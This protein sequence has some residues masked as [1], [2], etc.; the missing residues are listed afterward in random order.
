MY[1]K[2]MDIKQGKRKW[3]AVSARASVRSQPLDHRVNVK[4]GVGI[5]RY[6]SQGEKLRSQYHPNLFN[7]FDFGKNLIKQG[8]RLAPPTPTG[9][10]AGVRRSALSHG[11]AGADEPLDLR[12]EV[13]AASEGSVDDELR[14]SIAPSGSAGGPGP[15]PA[16]LATALAGADRKPGSAGKPA[17]G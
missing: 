17:K 13:A 14:T 5:A 9:G 10:T 2:L 11:P 12:V 7:Y 6:A 4:N 15:R 1:L 3:D 8:R 16:G